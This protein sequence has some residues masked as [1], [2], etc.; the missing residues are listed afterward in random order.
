[1]STDTRGAGEP[2]DADADSPVAI[3]AD[4]L[5]HNQI[6]SKNP[7]LDRCP[8]ASPVRRLQALALPV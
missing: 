7:R 1:M 2:V 3:A 5:P 4:A 6:G 8:A